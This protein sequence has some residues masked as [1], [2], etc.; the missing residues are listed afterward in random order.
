MPAWATTGRGVLMVGHDGTSTDPNLGTNTGTGLYQTVIRSSGTNHLQVRKSDDASDRLI[1]TDTATTTPDLVAS[2]TLT[3]QGN[4]ILGTSGANTLTVNAAGAYAALQTF[5]AGATFTAGQTVT[6]NGTVQF[7][8]P[9]SAAASASLTLT[10]S[11]ADVTG[12]SLSLTPGVWRLD[13][14][15]YFVAS[16]AGDV[17]GLGIG[18]LATTGGTATIAL[19]TSLAVFTFTDRDGRRDGRADLARDGHRDHDREAPG[20][21]KRRHGRQHLRAAPHHDHGE[22]RM[23]ALRTLVGA[24]RMQQ[25]VGGFGRHQLA[26]GRHVASG[27]G[28]DRVAVHQEVA[29]GGGQVDEAAGSLVVAEVLAPVEEAAEGVDAAIGEHRTPPVAG[30]IAGHAAPAGAGTP[31]GGSTTNRREP[32]GGNGHDART[33]GNVPPVAVE[34]CGWDWR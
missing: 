26:D 9:L 31:A 17:G 13:G 18:Q 6:G 7:K 4:T 5:N 33:G 14:V 2:T 28:A 30:R 15:F 23:T 24:A 25:R 12:A 32:G 16:G 1:V 29:A 20:P 21:E 10:T 3:S 11:M 27:L 19:S 34:R 8:T 22:Q